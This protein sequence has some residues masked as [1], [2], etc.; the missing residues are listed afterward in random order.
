MPR[1]WTIIGILL[2]AFVIYAVLEPVKL[3]GYN[4]RS[5]GESLETQVEASAGDSAC[6][7]AQ[8]G[9]W[10]CQ[11]GVDLNRNYRLTVGDDGC[12]TG[13]A[14]PSKSMPRPPADEVEGCVNI[15]N[16]T[17]IS[18]LVDI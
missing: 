12:W 18:N 4:G 1:P 7:E 10:N 5:L 16:I 8:G 15:L 9:V 3:F 11:T 6:Q 2:V 14:V 13:M 17:G